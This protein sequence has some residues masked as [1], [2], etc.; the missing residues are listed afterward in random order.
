MATASTVAEVVERV[1]DETASER[2]N[3]V[4]LHDYVRER[5]RSG[6]NPL[7]DASD[8]DQTL[9]AGVG[10][11][12]PKSRLMAAVFQEAGHEVHHHFVVL[13]REIL[14]G[15]IPPSRYWMLPDEISHCYLDVKVEGTWR[16]IDSYILDTAFLVGARE[17]LVADGATM[18]YGIHRD[19]VN[20][21]DGASD[22]FAQFH[23]DL[24]IDDHGHVDDLDAFFS[25]HR[26]RNRA[27]GVPFNVMFKL[28]GRRGVV[29]INTSIDAIRRRAA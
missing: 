9:A 13:P 7:F 20:T 29:P 2:V 17:R 19:S 4:A 21:W 10:H 3:A 1:V 12:I 28:M 24:M 15:V 8:P 6:F 14:R 25:E 5:V 26:Y 22:A 23:P 27:F 18:G 16:S 11:C